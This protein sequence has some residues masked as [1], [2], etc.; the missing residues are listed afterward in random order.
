MLCVT[1]FKNTS[2]GTVHTSPENQILNYQVQLYRVLRWTSAAYAIKFVAKWLLE[3]RKQAEKSDE[4]DAD[5]PEIHASAAGLKAYGCVLAADG[6][7]DLRR[8]CGGHGYL[9]SSG[10]AP[11]EADFKGPNTTA[12]G[13]YVILSLQ[14]A[15]FR[16]S[17]RYCT[18]GL[19]DKLPGLTSCLAPLADGHF[20]PVKDGKP[21]AVGTLD[22]L[23]WN[24]A[25]SR[26]YLLSLFQYRT[27]VACYKA[28]RALH[29]SVEVEKLSIDDARNSNA[30]LLYTTSIAHVKYFM[31]SKFVESVDAIP[32]S[33][34]DDGCKFALHKL[35]LMFALQDIL[36]GEGWVGLIARMKYH[37]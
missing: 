16:T 31:L 9:M 18:E 11:L 32:D 12:E 27:M 14:T 13:D 28:N 29:Y 37:L 2:A 5:L 34:A 33:E 30:R 22:K 19:V 3:R 8:A 6:I 23:L 10:I 36:S 25:G 20:D 17:R 24:G 1:R 26:H 15:R 35:V 21:L 4:G 7:E